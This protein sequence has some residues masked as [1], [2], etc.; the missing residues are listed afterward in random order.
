MDQYLVIVVI[1]LGLAVLDLTVGVAND[2]VNFLNS[3]IGSRA[4]TFR[5]IMIIA[6]IG[7]LVGVTFSSGLMEVARKGIF[8]PSKFVMPELIIIF[9]AVMVTDVLLLDLFNTFSL[10]TSTTVSIIFELLG[11]SVAISLIKIFQSGQEISELFSYINTN[12]AFTIIAAIFLSIAIAFIFGSLIQLITRLIFT[13]D[14]KLK[15]RRYGSIWGAI[16][17]TMITFFITLKGAKGASFMT[18]ELSAWIQSNL[19][20]MALY[21]FAIWTVVLQL[22]IWFTKINILKIIVLAGTFALAMAFAANDLVN[23]IGAPLAALNSYQVGQTFADPLSAPMDALAQSVKANT[24][25]LLAAG[26]VMVVTLFVSRKARSVAFT[27]INLGRQEEGYER[28]ESNLISRVIVRSMLNFFDFVS[29]ITPEP[30]KRAFNRRLDIK[31]YKPDLDEN[32]KP[33]AFDLMRAAVILMVS[34][35]LISLATSLKLPLSTTYVTF[36]VAM[37]AA[38]PDKSWGRESAVYRVSG[39]VTV[40]AG[41]FFTALIAS[42]AAMVVAFIIYYGEIYAV[43]GLVGLAAF[44]FVRSSKLHKQR[45]EEQAEEIEKIRMANRSPEEIY[46]D[47]LNNLAIYLD[48][49]A[50]IT[51]KS[52]KGILKPKLKHLKKSKKKSKKINKKL[53]GLID[54]ILK[55]TKLAKEEYIESGFIYARAL[56]DLNGISDHLEFLAEQNYEYIDNNHQNF[57]EEQAEELRDVYESAGDILLTIAD[58]MREENFNREDEMFQKGDLFFKKISLYNKNQLKRVKETTSNLRRIRL[59]LDNLSD[60]ET[61]IR[62]AVSLYSTVKM[63]HDA[64]NNED[65]VLKEIVKNNP[66][67]EKQIKRDK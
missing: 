62:H 52:R 40:I 16:A 10:P 23:F 43:I 61:I 32:G 2:A 4:A 39:V 8:F 17:L 35:A 58:S 21:S 28:F 37:A 66:I 50:A 34:A 51:K 15:L 60:T 56:T 55:L 38:L 48:D 33:P 13:F 3:A 30:I 31:K 41:W 1:L 42:S 26:A 59:F 27:T 36:M 29:G 54:D 47:V 64:L 14:F 20:L 67:S 65:N 45:E 5:T 25:I 24:W 11:A 22:L 12:K 46:S 9:C 19:W 18:D 57:N 7:V 44:I 53:S 49:A 63:V 6:A